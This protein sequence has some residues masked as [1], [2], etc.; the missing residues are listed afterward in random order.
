MLCMCDI[1]NRCC[2]FPPVKKNW[3][4]KVWINIDNMNLLQ[5]K[6]RTVQWKQVK[7]E[8]GHSIECIPDADHL[9]AFNKTVLRGCVLAR[10]GSR[11]GP[12]RCAMTHYNEMVPHGCLAATLCTLWPCDLN[13]WPFDLIFIGGEVSWWSISVS[14]LAILVSAVSVLSCGQKDRITD[15]GDYWRRR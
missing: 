14:S 5:I 7:L 11:A 9:I 2:Y 4:L 13:L 10:R 12:S 3:N 15:A 6:S 1:G 8:N